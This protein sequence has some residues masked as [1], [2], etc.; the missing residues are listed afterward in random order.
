MKE[1]ILI[2]LMLFTICV[3]WAT[4]DESYS[5]NA[6]TGT[7]TPITGTAIASISSDDALSAAIPIGFTFA[8]G[9]NS[10]SSVMVS[11]NG[12]VGLGTAFTSNALSNALNSTTI[13][14][15]IAPLWYDLN[16][17]SGTAEYDLSG[18]VPNRIFAIPLQKPSLLAMDLLINTCQLGL[19]RED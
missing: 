2:M 1:L 17:V 4:I 15:V 18:V 16:V 19:N 5:F 7:Y 10:Y 3:T 12:W 8:Y 11:S 14:P 9:N 6:T 13:K